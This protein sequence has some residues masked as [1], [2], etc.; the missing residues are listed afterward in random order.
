MAPKL[1]I[2]YPPSQYT[3]IG[4]QEVKSESSSFLVNS[5][6]TAEQPHLA[7]QVTVSICIAVAAKIE[8]SIVN[9][10]CEKRGESVTIGHPSGRVVVEVEMEGMEVKRAGTVRTAR[11]LMEGQTYYIKERNYFWSSPPGNQRWAS[12]PIDLI[13]SQAFFQRKKLLPHNG[14]TFFACLRSRDHSFGCNFTD[15]FRGN[16]VYSSVQYERVVAVLTIELCQCVSIMVINL[17]E[18]SNYIYF[19]FTTVDMTLKV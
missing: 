16:H 15:S 6:S 5:M 9:R 12:N 13:W 7:V 4:G 10:A 14:C 19:H 18:I 8:G 11:K 1:A 2:V 3:T 17:D